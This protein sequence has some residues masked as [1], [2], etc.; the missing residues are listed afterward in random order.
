VMKAIRSDPAWQT[1]DYKQQPQQGLREAGD[2]LIIAGSAPLLLQKQAPTRDAADKLLAE[3][4]KAATEHA[5]ANDMLYYVDASRN[6]NP[7]PDLEKVRA[8]V[9]A[10]NSADDFINPPDLGIM[11]REIKRVAKGKYVLIPS[12]DQTRGHG[13]HTSAAVW[14]HYLAE[15]LQDSGGLAPGTSAS[16]FAGVAGSDDRVYTVGAGVTPPRAVFAPDPRYT[17]DA[18][19]MKLNG[20]V[21]LAV[22]VG[23]DGMVKEVKVTRPLLPS[24]DQSAIDTVKTWR[25]LPATK[26]GKP[27]A[28]RLN[29]ETTFNLY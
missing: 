11:E 4:E 14:R 25:F 15:L 3:R 29:I 5:D 8:P 24:L 6:Y 2:L 9:M 22:V 12:S 26:D 20:T 23:A 13:T 27:V 21:V 1:G 10:V 16:P 19:K 18:R 7:A 17:D 28:V